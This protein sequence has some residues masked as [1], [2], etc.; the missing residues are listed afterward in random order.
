MVVDSEAVA[1]TNSDKEASNGGSGGRR[2]TSVFNHIGAA[3]GAIAA[4]VA[5]SSGAAALVFALRPNLR[6]EPPPKELSAS[7]D[8]LALEPEVSFGDYLSRIG[9]LNEYRRLRDQ[10]LRSIV[11]RKYQPGSKGAAVTTLQR[12]LTQQGVYAGPANGVYGAATL[13]AVQRFQRESGTVP[14]GIVGP[15]TFAALFRNNPASFSR[16]GLAVFVD[17]RVKG[18]RVRQFGPLQAHIY[19]AKTHARVHDPNAVA[20]A[21]LLRPVLPAADADAA[22]RLGEITRSR[23][24]PAAPIDQRGKLLWLAAPSRAGT[25]LVRV[26]LYDLD[27]QL[28]DF[29]DTPALRLHSR[30]RRTPAARPR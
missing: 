24:R 12:L 7:I 10:L 6:P 19:D 30:T 16:P 25:F 9:A 1:E 11:D 13:R 28:V 5:L 18:F 2:P 3:V 23:L 17:V 15:A 27:G 20:L 8:K 4:I 29:A 22:V 14:D 26:E 21:S